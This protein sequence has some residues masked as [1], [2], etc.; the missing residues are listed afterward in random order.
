MRRALLSA[1]LLIAHGGGV[2][3]GMLPSP[4]PPSGF[5]LEAPAQRANPENSPLTGADILGV[6]YGSGPP[7]SIAALMSL[8]P[9]VDPKSGLKPARGAELRDAALS[10][11]AAGGL[12]AFAFANNENLRRRE[13]E[14]DR[15][16]DARFRALILPVAGEQTLIVPPA[17]SEEQ[18][19]FALGESGLVARETNRI[20]RISRSAS[21]SSQPPTWRSFLV[22]VWPDPVPP[23]DN[24]R[25]HDDDESKYWA[26]CV[27]EGWARGWKQGNE[28]FLDR[29]ARLESDLV[30]MARYGILLRAGLVEQPKVAVLRAAFRGSG[31]TV[32][33]GDTLSRITGGAS[34]NGGPVRTR[35]EMPQ[36]PI[37][38]IPGPGLQR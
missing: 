38:P 27:A 12:S 30:G 35:Q 33:Y 26:Q 36:G 31:E 1:A 9:G 17:I 11:G 16:F 15:T 2:Q 18:M 22:Q 25:P 8:R 29:L 37:A 6:P 24:L 23:D 14:L 28:I 20:Y 13:A 32:G 10:Y 21:L 5:D 34:L 4:A 7:P 3:A 19:A